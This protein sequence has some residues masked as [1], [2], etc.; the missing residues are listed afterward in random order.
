MAADTVR[1]LT[2]GSTEPWDADTIADPEACYAFTTRC[3][4]S[5]DFMAWDDRSLRFV[6]FSV[7]DVQSA[8]R[9]CTRRKLARRSK[10]RLYGASARAAHAS[11][12][13]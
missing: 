10:L 12:A 13:S 7:N 2:T 1:A 9:F 3:D 6:Q 4:S 11:Q 8:D 5:H